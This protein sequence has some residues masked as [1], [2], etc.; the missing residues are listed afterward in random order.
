M[1]SYGKFCL[2]LKTIQHTP[3][4]QNSNA[5]GAPYGAGW[6][7]C[8]HDH[9]HCFAS[10]SAVYPAAFFP[11]STFK[12]DYQNS[13]E[14]TALI[15]ALV[16]LIHLGFCHCSIVV[17][18]DSDVV[19][20]WTTNEHFRSAIAFAPSLLFL[21]LCEAFHIHIAFGEHIPNE[22]N[23]KCDDLSR[24]KLN[25]SRLLNTCGPHGPIYPSSHG[26]IQQTLRC[27]NLAQAT[28]S[29][30]DIYSLWDSA[31]SLCTSVTG[32]L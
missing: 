23:T 14:L 13:C 5:N 15:C 2:P 10:G 11:N 9:T 19:L 29:E 20:H 25:S 6:R 31:A 26:L 22:M 1:L 4:A 18:G 24:G 3:S 32:P 30:D 8:L 17:R 16:H 12:S 27:C 28:I 21:K 7:L